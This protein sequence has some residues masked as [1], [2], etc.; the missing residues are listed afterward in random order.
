MSP[1]HYGDSVFVVQLYEEDDETDI[2]EP[3]LIATCT[4]VAQA[5][6]ALRVWCELLML[7]WHD[8]LDAQKSD[9]SLA[10][11][12]ES[13]GRADGVVSPTAPPALRF[14]PTVADADALDRWFT[15]SSDSISY[16]QRPTVHGTVRHMLDTLI[17]QL[18]CGSW[19]WLVSETHL[20]NGPM[21]DTEELAELKQYLPLDLVHLIQRYSGEILDYPLL[22]D[23]CTQLQYYIKRLPSRQ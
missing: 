13:E 3:V 9:V 4:T 23:V 12:A 2:P 14:Q 6:T 1:G 17:N 15:T 19:T 16:A 21:P 5:W 11:Y 22:F 7:Y 10:E 18:P 20:R 8:F